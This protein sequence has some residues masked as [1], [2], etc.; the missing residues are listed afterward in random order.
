MANLKA[1]LRIVQVWVVNKSE[2]KLKFYFI[3]GHFYDDMSHLRKRV[4]VKLN[5]KNK[6]SILLDTG[7]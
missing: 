4:A 5:N 7:A 3:G 2:K 1:P 6:E